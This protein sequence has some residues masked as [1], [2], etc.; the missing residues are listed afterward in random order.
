MHPGRLACSFGGWGTITWFG[1]VS[2]LEPAGSWPR[3]SG[4]ALPGWQAGRVGAAWRGSSASVQEQGAGGC[5]DERW[6]AEAD[7]KLEDVAVALGRRGRCGGG[8]PR[9][10]GRRV[11]VGGGFS[12]VEHGEPGAVGADCQAHC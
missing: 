7:R 3:F 4:R 2:T 12:A 11:N 8:G 5:G 10:V 1:V 6:D 9:L